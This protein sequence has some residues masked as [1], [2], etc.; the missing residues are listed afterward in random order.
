MFCGNC[1]TKNPVINKFCRE[2]GT[3]L[4]ERV[5]RTLPEEA[6]ADL[7][8]PEPAP[9]V[10]HARVAVL[11]DAAFTYH[12]DGKMDQAV[13]T[14]LEAIA[15]SPRST[16]AHS[17]LSVI[18]EEKGQFDEAVAHL[19]Q[20]LEI[21]PNSA[22]DRENL[23]RLLG[24]APAGMAA[25][26]SPGPGGFRVNRPL[27]AA[28]A[29]AGVVL[30]LAGS[31]VLQGWRATANAP[32]APGTVRAGSTPAYG[33]PAAAGAYA[34]QTGGGVPVAAD[35]GPPAAAAQPAAT[36]AQP[37]AQP[38]PAPSPTATM[39]PSEP[40][41]GMIPVPEFP[42]EPRPARQRPSSPAPGDET[43][44]PLPGPQAPRAARTPPVVF[45]PVGE[46]EASRPAPRAVPPPAPS[47]PPSLEPTFTPAGGGSV[48]RPRPAVPAEPAQPAP[49]L[50]VKK[51]E[52]SPGENER[53]GQQA[54]IDGR[55]GTAIDH[56]HKALGGAR[57]AGLRARIHQQLADAYR[58]MGRGDDAEGEYR[59]AIEEYKDQLE[60][61]TNTELARA[62][63]RSSEAA[64]RALG[65]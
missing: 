46:P 55:Y 24:E 14:C 51:Q 4:P 29:S 17:L 21:N 41:A 43:L 36:A 48:S 53:W 32:E 26:A 18:Y 12:R 49:R 54:L 10:D 8:A 31:I 62:G 25:T 57:A 22:A 50:V 28:F 15:L 2:C 44:E 11:M 52:G 58:Q 60:Q 35:S 45:V 3:R 42:P 59:K 1:G 7:R 5:H 19:R 38:A 65:L 47:G 20:V 61:G 39:P 64:L 9:L 13:E 34:P 23:A 33:T 6:F 63:I 27:V 40:P 56:F 37:V 16:S 30:V